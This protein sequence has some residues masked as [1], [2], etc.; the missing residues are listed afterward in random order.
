[1]EDI[2]TQARGEVDVR[3]IGTITKLAKGPSYFRARRR[4]LVIGCSIGDRPPAGYSNAGTLGCFVVGRKSPHYISVL[5]N[6][7]VIAAE[8]E[9]SKGSPFVQPG[10]LDGGRFSADVVGELGRYIR[11]RR[12]GV[13]HVDAALGDLYDD[14]EYDPRTIGDFGDLRGLGSVYRLPPKARVRKAGRTTGQTTGRVTAFDV[15][16]VRV[17]YDM[18]VIR[19]DE[20]IEIEGTGKS[21]FSDSGDSGSMI[22]DDREQAIGLLFAGGTTGGS[23]GKGLTYA[24]PIGTVLDA[25]DVDLAL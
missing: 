6:N 17:G 21:A 11:L 7:H 18:G 19:F 3:E 24:N 15:D 8:N 9:K 1:M 14:V 13:N 25:L 20:Q 5:T 12:S 4:P 16:N 22:V 23:N 10:T 2:R